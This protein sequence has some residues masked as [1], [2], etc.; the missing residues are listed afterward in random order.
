[1]I[2]MTPPAVGVACIVAAT[3]TWGVSPLYYALLG[4]IPPLE[5]V[6]HRIVW[7]LPPI[8][9]YAL[10]TGRR[11]RF[12][13]TGRDKRKLAALAL[14][15]FAIFVNWVVFLYAIQIGQTAQASFGYYIYPLAVLLLG[16]LIF[17]ETIS[18]LQWLAAAIAT[19]GVVWIGLRFG[20]MPWISLIV[21]A[22]FAFYGVIRKAAQVGPMVG[23]LWEL[24]VIL[25]VLL[26]YFIWIGGGQFFEDWRDALLLI[27]GSLFTGI[28]LILFVEA[29]KRLRFST[30]GVL[31]YINPTLQLVSALILGE[32]FGQ[33]RAIGFGLIWIAVA[34]Y[35]AELIRQDRAARIPSSAASGDAET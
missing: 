9:I 5:V 10:M 24:L 14:S 30:V 6:V 21:M 29:T 13:E 22:T 4:H 33:D 20:A 19:L 25:P 16:V 11:A 32:A 28:P 7:S 26:G 3:V 12:V 1:M 34:L 31:F 18:R 8:I 15:T 35:C 17:Q 2:S 23:V 27:G